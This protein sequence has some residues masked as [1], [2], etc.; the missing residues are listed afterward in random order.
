M[1]QENCPGCGRLLK[2]DNNMDWYCVEKV[3]SDISHAKIESVEG[4]DDDQV[5]LHFC[6][7]CKRLLAIQLS[8]EFGGEVFVNSESVGIV[9]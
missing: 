8:T 9:E 1:V 2:W 4:I 3:P 5:D 6:P 7:H